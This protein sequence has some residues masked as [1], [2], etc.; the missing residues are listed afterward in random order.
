MVEYSLPNKWSHPFPNLRTQ[1][2][3]NPLGY[4]ETIRRK[5][6]ARDILRRK[7][8]N[9]HIKCLPPN[10]NPYDMENLA[11]AC[12]KSLILIHQPYNKEKKIFY[13][14]CF[15]L[16]EDPKEAAKFCQQWD[17][18]RVVDCFGESKVLQIHEGNKTPQDFI[19]SIL[20]AKSMKAE[21]CLLF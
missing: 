18:K 15:M 5:L 17:R 1:R 3:I 7:V 10:F 19:R 2:K 16:V 21:V 8:K 20:T 11:S 6:T 13:N 4:N 14:Y 9:L 12:R